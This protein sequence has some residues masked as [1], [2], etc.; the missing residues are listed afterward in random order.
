MLKQSTN[1]CVVTVY[2][3]TSKWRSK[4]LELVFKEL[5]FLS[6]L[7]VG[8]SGNSTLPFLRLQAD[9]HGTPF[10][11]AYAVCWWIWLWPAIVFSCLSP[12]WFFGSW[13][14][15][16]GFIFCDWRMAGL[17]YDAGLG[18]L[19]ACLATQFLRKL[20]YKLGI[21]LCLLRVVV[22]G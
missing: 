9:V 8:I 11:P 18:D 6:A 3:I 7:S 20:L 13:Y 14:L 19:L 2:F 10:P 4:Y 15:S 17:T 5:V 12:T 21:G 16:F 1:T 22:H